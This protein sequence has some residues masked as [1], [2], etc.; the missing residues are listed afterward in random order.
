[1]NETS[2]IE[3]SKSAI[4]NNIRY[5]QKLL[6]KN[7][8]LS[9]VVKGNAYGHG[10]DTFVPLAESCGLRHFSVYSAH[11]AEKVKKAIRCQSNI[12]VMGALNKTEVQWAVR[13]QISF[14]VF[15]FRRLY[16]AK[17]VA[18]TLAKKA[19]VHI[20]LETGLNRTGFENEELKQLVDYLLKNQNFFEIKG[21]CSHLSGAESISN[22]KRIKNQIKKFTKLSANLESVLTVSTK[23]LACSAAVVMY[24]EVR[25]QLARIGIMQYGFWPSKEVQVHFW[26]LKKAKDDPLQRV[27]TWKTYVSA[28]KHVKAGEFIGYGTAV[29]AEEDMKV[30][31][32]PVGYANGYSRALSNKG[33]VLI[34]NKRVD[35]IGYVNMNTTLVNVTSLPNVALDD[36]VVLIGSQGELNISV[37]SFSEMSN[38]LNYELLARLPDSIPKR[39]VE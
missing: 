34:N 14:F 27:L 36:E 16:Q 18:E 25:Y 39:I 24:P 4:Q 8:L 6:G 21:I 15:D 7:C 1:M 28:L 17:Q 19:H 2:Y 3:I 29:L 5:I 26:G 33:K 35:V 20:E 32:L 10:I 23:H 9:S 38:V 30:A 12:M 22:Y 11:E 37:S 13:N 31:A